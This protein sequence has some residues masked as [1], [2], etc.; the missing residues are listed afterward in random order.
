VW[1]WAVV[2][3]RATYDSWQA[4]DHLSACTYKSEEEFRRDVYFGEM[5]ESA[6]RDLAKSM[7]D[8]RNMLNKLSEDIKQGNA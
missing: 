5:R 1:A 6:I 4:S 8:D 3:V 2:E 7:E